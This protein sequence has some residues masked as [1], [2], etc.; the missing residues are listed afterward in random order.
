[1]DNIINSYHPFQGESLS[2]YEAMQIGENETDTSMS[3]EEVYILFEND[4]GETVN[5]S[6]ETTFEAE[7]DE[8]EELEYLDLVEDEEGFI[9]FESEAVDENELEEFHIPEEEEFSESEYFNPWGEGLNNELLLDRLYADEIFED[10]LQELNVEEEE[11]YEDEAY[12]EPFI[13]DHVGHSDLPS[14][15]SPLVVPRSRPVPFARLPLENSYWPVISTHPRGKEIAYRYGSQRKDHHGNWSRRFLANRAGNKRYHA[16]VDLYANHKDKIVACEDGRIVNFYPFY[17]GT[18]CLLI[19]HQGLVINYGEVEKNSLEANGLNIGDYVKAGQVIAFV[20]KMYRSSMLHFETYR[21]GTRENHRYYQGKRAPSQLL[22][23]TKYLLELRKRMASGGQSSSSG[24]GAIHRGASSVISKINTGFNAL[25]TITYGEQDPNK[26]TD[27]I[28]Y[29]RHP[30]LN[31]RKLKQSDHSLIQEWKNIKRDI[32][33]PLVSTSSVS[34]T[35]TPSKS[36]STSSHTPANKKFLAK[37]KPYNHLIEAKARKYNLNPN[38]IRAI[39]AAESNGDP[40][41]TSVANYRGLMQAGRSRSHYTPVVSIEAGAKKFAKFK[42]LVISNFKKRSG[43]DLSS[44]PEKTLL[45]LTLASY[46]AGPVTVIKALEYAHQ[47]G[48]WRNWLDKEHYQRALIFSGGYHTYKKCHRGASQQAIREAK[49]AK[50]KFAGWRKSS[51]NWRNF[52]DPP[53]FAQ[54]QM[55]AI[56]RCWV[57]TKHQNTIPYLKRFEQYI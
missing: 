18:Y 30:E 55:P 19:A 15:P 27:I 37:L 8:F 5:K 35:T 50:W 17:R 38:I 51:V 44:A 36:L 14:L 25:R 45:R 24:L 42:A 47:A 56:M 43:V 13:E 22:N 34:P 21:E 11:L 2:P 46:N 7:F 41:K 39:I 28:F 33:S 23:P 40:N 48:N 32:I 49:N 4:S 31:G 29:A 52:Q 53:L 20:G 54:I 3:E 26:L 1:M 12:K 9:D 6:F 16:G 57:N 10:E